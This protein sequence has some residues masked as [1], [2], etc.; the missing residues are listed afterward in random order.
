MSI[1]KIK[2]LGVHELIEV[3]VN[4][5]TNT[6]ALD[7]NDYHANDIKL[8]IPVTGTI[9]G[10]LLNYKG[11][12][13]SLGEAVNEKPH[14]AP[15]IAPILYIKPANT[16]NSYGRAIPM[17]EEISELEVGAALGIVIGKRATCVS[18]EEALDYVAGY[19]V[20]NDV[21]VPHESVYR[22]AV[23]HKSRDGFCPVGPWIVDREAVANPDNL[24]VRVFI[25]DELCQENNTENLIRP[26]AKLLSD[27]T[28]YMTLSKGDVL[29][30]GVPENSPVVKV[31]DNIRVEI[32]NVGSLENKVVLEQKLVQE[33]IK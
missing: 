3:A 16:F 11:A 29:L 12:L 4:P 25:N 32:E 14:N 18:E 6:L 1:A 27:V 13:E 19:T 9:F 33:A 8:D 28:D 23:Q 2:M 5:A 20:V 31:G 22:P 30:I 26:V 24:A 7:G 15:P 17:P 21:S 10:T